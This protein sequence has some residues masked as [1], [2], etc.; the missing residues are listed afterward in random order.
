MHE[1]QADEPVLRRTQA[2]KRML[3]DQALHSL[4]SLRD[5]AADGKDVR[6][7]DA[8]HFATTISEAA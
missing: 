6:L 1:G 3:T 4:R 8:H 2:N 5:Q 7:Q